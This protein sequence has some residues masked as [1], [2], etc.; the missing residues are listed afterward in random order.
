MRNS[1]NF[2]IDIIDVIA[3]AKVTNLHALLKYDMLPQVQD[4]SEK[5]CSSCMMVLNED[6]VVVLNDFLLAE[7]ETL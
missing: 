2:Y 1:G 7:T 5:N 3:S 4:E 6:D